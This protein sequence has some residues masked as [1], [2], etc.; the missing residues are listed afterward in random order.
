[1]ADFFESV[2]AA[3]PPGGSRIERAGW[4]IG[5]PQPVLVELERAGAISGEVLDVG[6]GT[7]DNALYL[8]GLG[9]QVLGLD[10]APSAIAHAKAKAERTHMPVGFAVADARSMAGYEHRFDTVLD[11]GLLHTFGGSDRRRYIRAL[12]SVGKLGAVVHVLAVSDAA[13]PGPGPRRLA[14]QDLRSAFGAGWVIETLRRG[15][16]LGALPG[17]PHGVIPA[18]LL[19]ARLRAGA[20]A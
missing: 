9:Y 14:Q 8:A 1:M 20:G 4:D 13:P 2:Y 19:T 6:C 7:G 17:H 18:W 10:A 16:M 5:G 11:S 15:E 3:D 12:R